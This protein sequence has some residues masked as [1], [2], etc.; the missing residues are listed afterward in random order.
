MKVAE[1]AHADCL[2]ITDG[3]NIVV[4]DNS[5]INLTPTGVPV[6]GVDGVTRIP[7]DDGTGNAAIQIGAQTGTLTNLLINHNYMVG[8]VYTINSNN[9]GEG[10]NGNITGAYTNNVFAGYHHYGPNANIGS[11]MTF[12]NTNV[13]EATRITNS[14]FGVGDNIEQYWHLTGGAPVNGTTRSSTI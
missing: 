9:S 10:V 5:L 8:G 13:W 11:G 4:E 14:W 1:G 6:L 7:K 2:Q 3:N 12:D